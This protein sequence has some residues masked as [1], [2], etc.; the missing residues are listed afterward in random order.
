LSELKPTDIS[1]IRAARSR[2][3]VEPAVSIRVSP[4]SYLAAILIGTYL[5]AL[6]FYLEIDLAGVICFALA[7]VVVPF[8]ALNDKVSCD[9]KRLTRTGLAPRSWVWFN[10]SRRRMKM[11]DIEQV[12]THA[13]RTLRRGGSVV[14]RYRTMFRGKGLSVTIASGGEDYRRL[15]KAVLPRLPDNVLDTRSMEL[16]DHLTDPKETALRATSV[17]PSADVL[18]G[19]MRKVKGAAGAQPAERP[20]IGK[21]DEL[22]S[23]ANELR[24]AGHLPQAL[25]AFRR[26]L[27]V[28]PRDGHL[29]FE[30]ARCLHSFA[31]SRRDPKLARRA[32]AASRLS[33][34]NAADDGDLLAR[35]GEW[36]F[37]IGEW[38][39]AGSVFQR[40]TEKIGANFRAAR[41]MAEIA[42]RDGKI[43]HVIHHFAAAGRMAETAAL[44]RWSRSEADYFSHL[45]DDEEYMEMEISRVNLLDTV[46]RSKRTAL[47]IAFLAIPAVLIGVFL[48]DSLVAQI[49]WAVSTVALLIWCG[50]IVSARLLSPRIPYEM[51]ASDE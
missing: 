18:E 39:R 8:L 11:I 3:A 22:R 38:R 12:E 45:N 44:R 35:L 32:L 46:E 16:R 7:W 51:M 48:D 43:A 34:R 41:G 24:L 37:E 15:I 23:L 2:S 21:V 25:E 30:F 14:Y 19:A 13:V 49:G 27:I 47:R 29:L 9:G 40:V 6:F 36:Y 5:S 42:L 50:L 33:E 26:A 17:L 1:G 28:T 31:G 20:E 4:H 10:G